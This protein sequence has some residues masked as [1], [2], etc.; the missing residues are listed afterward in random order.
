MRVL[1]LLLSTVKKRIYGIVEELKIKDP[2]K[3]RLLS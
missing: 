1:Q 2:L 3:P